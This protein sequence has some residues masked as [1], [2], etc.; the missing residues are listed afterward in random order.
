MNIDSDYWFT[1]LEHIRRQRNQIWGNFKIRKFFSKKKKFKN[2]WVMA[3]YF[4]QSI[5]QSTYNIEEIISLTILVQKLYRNISRRNIS[6]SPD[7][8]DR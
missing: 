1:L 4:P 5:P 8:G 7:L 2:T 6:P 3:S